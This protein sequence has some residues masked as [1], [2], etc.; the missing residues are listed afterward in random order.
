[1]NHATP[2]HQADRDQPTVFAVDHDVSVRESLQLLLNC[3]GWRPVLFESAQLFL[4][5]SRFSGPSCLVLDVNMPGLNGLDSR[6]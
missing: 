1:M 5:S 4:G 2:S 6:E 3:A